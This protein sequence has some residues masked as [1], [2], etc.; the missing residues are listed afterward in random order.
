[1]SKHLRV[2]LVGLVILLTMACSFGYEGVNFGDDPEVSLL[3]DQTAT[4]AQAQKSTAPVSSN[5]QEPQVSSGSAQSSDPIALNTGEHTYAVA[6][7]NFDC[8]C[9]VDGDMRVG[10]NVSG[11]QLEYSVSGGVPD[12]YQKIG[13]NTFKRTFMGYYILSS[14]SG[15]QATETVVEEERH[16]II[17]LNNQGYILEHYQGAEASPCCFHTFTLGTAP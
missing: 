1:M 6:A 11:D 7:T 10:L 4:A 8:T 2:I 5:T 12:I 9:Q 16:T 17:I 14:G 13:E 15:S 3:E